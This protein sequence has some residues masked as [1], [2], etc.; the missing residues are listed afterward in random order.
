M[1]VHGVVF[2]LDGTLADTL[3][4]LT[5]AVNVG[6]R[7]LGY[8]P[9]PADEVRQWIGEGMMILCRRAVTAAAPPGDAIDDQ[10]VA[11]MAS[12]FTAHYRAHRL[13]KTVPYPGI[14]ELLDELAARGLKMA[15]FS[16]KPHDHTVALMAALFDRWPWSVVEGSREDRPRKPDPAAGREVL[17]RMGL[18]PEQ[19]VM[20][21]DSAIDVQ[22][23]KNVGAVAVGAT[24]GF[25]DRAELLE[26]GADHIIDRPADLLT[27]LTPGNVV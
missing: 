4:D 2:D 13:D 15:V 19:A 6:L 14:P 18:E 3:V 22:A 20:V 5:D 26:A 10:T 17:A 7:Q 9:R 1:L 12:V 16:N 25:R 23:A 27:F 21:G 8:P 11:A 24:W